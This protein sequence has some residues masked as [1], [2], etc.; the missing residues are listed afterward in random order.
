ME[1]TKTRKIDALLRRRNAIVFAIVGGMRQQDGWS[2]RYIAHRYWSGW[3]EFKD[4]KTRVRDLQRIRIRELNERGV[5]AYIV[6]FTDDGLCVQDH[7][8]TVLA[9]CQPETLLETLQSIRGSRH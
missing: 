5:E 8:D 3:I 4:T 6:R 1:G 2:D 9:N 7:A